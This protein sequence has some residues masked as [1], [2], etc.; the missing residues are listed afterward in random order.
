MLANCL[1][2]QTYVCYRNSLF[3]LAWIEHVGLAAE[4]QSIL[5]I[6]LVTFRNLRGK[7]V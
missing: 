4:M 5:Y 6:E 1:S 7:Y 2:L 3:L